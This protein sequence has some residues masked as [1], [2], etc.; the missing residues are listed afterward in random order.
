[1]TFSIVAF[2]TTTVSWGV[3]VAS[4]FLAVGSVVPWGAAG[5]GAV[6]TQARANLSYGPRAIGLLD[7]GVSASEVVLRLT[8]SDPEFPQR[9]VG[10]VDRDGRAATFTGEEC[11]DWAGGFTGNGYAVQGN[12][13]AG[14]EVLDAMARAFQEADPFAHRL[15][16]ALAA[17]D[18]AG[19]DRR[20]RQS[21]ALRM[22][23]A[24]ASYGGELD[25]AVD[26]RVD[27]HPDPVQELARLLDLHELIYGHPDPDTLIPLRGKLGSEV[28]AALARLGFD[29][30]LEEAL[31]RWAGIENFEERLVRGK[32]D[33]LI[34][35]ALRR[36]A[37]AR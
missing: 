1:M 28:G 7:E 13:L 21:A 14:P 20:G 22:W 32:I 26:L 16:G 27:D 19:G 8:S 18:Q 24:G 6:A 29:G 30:D 9:Q 37:G 11:V 31:E 15:L 10:V 12:I 2:D 33:P 25:I 17:G 34:L 35:E 36:Q 23:R 5:A 4:K 3:A